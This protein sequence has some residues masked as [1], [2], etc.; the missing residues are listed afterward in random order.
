VA[1]SRECAL[2][3]NQPADILEHAMVAAPRALPE[4]ERRAGLSYRVE[5]RDGAGAVLP[6]VAEQL[7]RAEDGAWRVEVDPTPALPELTAPTAADRGATRWLQ[8]DDARILAAARAAVGDARDAGARMAALERYVREHIANKSMRIGYASALETLDAREGD[9]TEH[10]VLLA[11]LGRALDIPTRVVNGLAYAPSF[12]GREHVFVPHAW[13]QAWTGDGWQS[14]DAALAG[15]DA[16]HIAFS[17]GDGDAAGFYAGVNLLG[18][19]RI[20]DAEPLEAE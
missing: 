17:A 15:F 16:G 8:S 3:P 14:Y 12:A 10:A 5:L 7:A 18:N 6:S 1:C 20:V 2:A 11:A 19:V 9:C 4:A 13:V